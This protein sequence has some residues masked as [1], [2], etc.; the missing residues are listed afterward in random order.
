MVVALTLLVFGL[1]QVPVAQL[2]PWYVAAYLLTGAC[3]FGRVSK[4]PSLRQSLAFLL[5]GAL[6]V[7]FALL[8]RGFSCG[9]WL[10]GATGLGYGAEQ[11]DSEAPAPGRAGAY[12][13][14]GQ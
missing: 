11:M 8:D 2:L 13:G 5:P 3:I 4:P 14:P 12:T 1:T 6:L 10:L 7:G 9:C